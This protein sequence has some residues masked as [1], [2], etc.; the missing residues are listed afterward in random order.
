MK[1]W[2]RFDKHQY[3][4]IAL[5]VRFTFLYIS[6][7]SS[8]KKKK[9]KKNVKSSIYMFSRE[10]ERTTSHFLSRILYFE[11]DHRSLVEE[12]FAKELQTVALPDYLA[13]TPEAL[14]VEQRCLR[15]LEVV[16]SSH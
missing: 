11:A 15:I 14:V 1:D 16:S 7:P 8:E 10:R 12:K 6:L 5:H 3:Q 9:Q 2:P 13:E 4:K